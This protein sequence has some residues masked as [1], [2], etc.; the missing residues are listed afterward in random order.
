MTSIHTL[1]TFRMEISFDIC[2]E[3][4]GSEMN[5]NRLDISAIPTEQHLSSGAFS[6]EVT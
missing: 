3:F 4:L 6:I 1:I 5:D 2:S